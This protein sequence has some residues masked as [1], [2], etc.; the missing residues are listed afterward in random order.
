MYKAFPAEPVSRIPRNVTYNFIRNTPFNFIFDVAIDI[1]Q[2][3]R[4]V[5]IDFGENRATKM[6][7][8]AIILKF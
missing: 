7:A 6:A 1:D 4:K 2:A 5:P 3:G 8:E